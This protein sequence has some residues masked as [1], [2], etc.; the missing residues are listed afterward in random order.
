MQH[1]ENPNA[2]TVIRVTD[3]KDDYG[4]Y[5]AQIVLPPVIA[6]RLPAF[7][8]KFNFETGRVF[9]VEDLIKYSNQIYPE[10]ERTV[11]FKGL[12]LSR[13]ISYQKDYKV[14]LFG[15]NTYPLSTLN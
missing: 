3:A 5:T 10:I 14:T 6:Q 7:T 9:M 4:V 11:N 13:L 8:H 15:I 2:R 12:D 1:Y